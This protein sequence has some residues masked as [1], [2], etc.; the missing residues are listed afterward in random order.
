M[1]SRVHAGAVNAGRRVLVSL[2]SESANLQLSDLFERLLELF[3]ENKR[4]AIEC[5]SLQKPRVFNA[6][7]VNI[8]VFRFHI[9]MCFSQ[10]N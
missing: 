8:C 7:K 3:F 10:V 4:S 2:L 5:V 9:R 1:T 6:N